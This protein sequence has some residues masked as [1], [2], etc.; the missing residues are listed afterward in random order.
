M[1]GV[2]VG[3]LVTATTPVPP[4]PLPPLRAARAPTT[5]RST[6]PVDRVHVLAGTSNSR[7][8][9]YP[10]AAVL[11]G[12]VKLS[13]DNQGNVWNEGSEYTVA[14]VS[15]FSHL[16]AFGLSGLSLM[17]VV[18]RLEVDPTS[19]RSHAGAPDGPF[20][21]MWT[22]GDRSRVDKATE[23]ASPGY[24][25]VDLLD[26][27]VTVECGATA[28]VGYLRLTYPESD[29]SRLVVDFDFPAEEK[30]EV[31]GVE[32]RRTGPAEF[33][34][35]GR[36]RNQYAGTHDVS[37]V[38]QL[39]KA[40]AA[41]RTWQNGAYGGKDTNYGTAWRR[42]VTVA[43]LDGASGTFAGGAGSGA[44]LDVATAAGERGTVRSAISLVDAAGAR[45]RTCS[46]R[47][48]TA[49]PPATAPSTT[50]CATRPPW[51][52]STRTR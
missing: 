8:Q 36:Q 49:P 33:E 21:G 12:L 18:G 46:T 1:L 47:R 14:S 2:I 42:P 5:G 19:S 29:Q 28:R 22:A 44:V 20:G 25:A 17:P 4:A 40:P 6:A 45:G 10:G 50:P 37:F 34:G 26:Y 11:F 7:W 32:F 3:Q 23:R 48:C 9:L 31:L 16:H 30:T 13:P 24:Y 15:G 35:H 39:S 52:R 27:G 41:V 38:V 51:S 43:P